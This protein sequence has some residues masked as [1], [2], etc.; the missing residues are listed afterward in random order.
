MPLPESRDGVASRV[1]LLPYD[2]NWPGA[3]QAEELRIRNF[4]ARNVVSIQ[5]VGSTAVPGLAAKGTIDIVAGLRHM[6][7]A[8][9]CIRKLG[10]L[11]YVHGIEFDSADHKLLYRSRSHSWTH[12]VHLVEYH[13]PLWHRYVR[14]R[15]RLCADESKRRAYQLLKEQLARE[16]GEDV[17]RYTSAKSAFICEVVGLPHEPAAAGI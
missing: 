13:S 15:D 1:T 10:A 2:E 9:A 16:C 8:P 5:H 11:G 12:I 4:I 7:D 6:G 17:R 14:F 3:Y